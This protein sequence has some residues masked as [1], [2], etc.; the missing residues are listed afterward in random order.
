[1]CGSVLELILKMSYN[2]TLKQSENLEDATLRENSVYVPQ[3]DISSDFTC[4]QYN[5]FFVAG[6]SRDSKWR[7]HQPLKCS[8]HIYIDTH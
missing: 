1:M 6:V 4:L 7:L 8:S 3:H 5:A 2:F